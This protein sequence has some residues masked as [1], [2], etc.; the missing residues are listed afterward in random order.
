MFLNSEPCKASGKTPHRRYL[1]GSEYTSD[2]S[3]LFS[4]SWQELL[5]KYYH[6]TQYNSTRLIIKQM[7]TFIELTFPVPCIP[8]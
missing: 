7:A 8:Y 6:E 3:G 4:G 1:K 2:L 5:E